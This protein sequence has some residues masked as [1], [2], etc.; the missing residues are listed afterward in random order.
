[1]VVVHDRR[2]AGFPLVAYAVVFFGALTVKDVEHGL[3]DVSVLLRLAAG[4]IFFEVD[5]QRLPEAVLGLNILPAVLL[6]TAMEGLLA[7][8]DDP[9]KRTQALQL[10]REIVLARYGAYERAIGLLV[11]VA[12]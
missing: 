10:V 6:R 3:V 5:V 1:A 9:R 4:R 2:V 11:I 12:D 7:A 8:L